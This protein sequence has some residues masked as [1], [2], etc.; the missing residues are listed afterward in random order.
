MP[1]TL[2]EFYASDPS[3]LSRISRHFKSGD[4]LPED[5]TRKLCASK[6]VFSAVDVH[7]Q[8]FYSM[9]DQRFHG[10]PKVKMGFRAIISL[11]L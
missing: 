3:V 7:T 11:L 2:M 9:L 1:S 4:S 5:V 10:K 6:K 8:L